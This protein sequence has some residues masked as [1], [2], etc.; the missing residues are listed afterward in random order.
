[1]AVRPSLRPVGADDNEKESDG[2]SQDGETA[3][4]MIVE[5]Q[6]EAEDE[7]E[8]QEPKIRRAPKEPTKAERE[9]HEA[10]HLPYREWCRHCVRGRGRNKPHKTRNLG[11]EEDENKVPRISLDY[12]FMSKEEEIASKNPLMVM[13]DEHTQNKYMRAV[14]QKGLGENREMDWLME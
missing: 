14:G 13:V 9:R 12:F 4:H 6:E 11:G 2:L 1:M 7:E 10:L 8:V 5:S 3:E